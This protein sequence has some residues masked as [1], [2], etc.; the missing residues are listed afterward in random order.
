MK[1]VIG[2]YF[3]IIAGPVFSQPTAGTTGLLNIPTAE[4]QRDGTFMLGASYLP[5]A[6]TP[7]RFNYNTGNYY[8]NITFLPFL[9]INY[10]CTFLRVPGKDY[11][12]Q[13]RSFAIRARL[14]KEKKHIPAVL[15]G[16]NDIY[17]SSPGQANKFFTTYFV[18]TKNFAGS[19]YL[20]ET[21][22]GY[23]PE[24]FRTNRIKGMFGGVSFSPG[25][26][27]AVKLIAEYDSEAVN[28]GSSFLF[29]NRL[30]LIFFLYDMNYPTGSLVYKVYL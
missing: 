30:Q 19:W 29:C 4:M 18:A 25:M 20:L 13:D 28:V 5:E 10:R 12:N 22:V 23:G 2:L 7:A 11:L 21:S 26:I 16:G 9:E 24:L 14:W 3:L 17:S 6:I 8:F 27:P 15:V 1:R